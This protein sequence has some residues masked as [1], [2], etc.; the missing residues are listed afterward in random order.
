M[1]EETKQKLLEELKKEYNVVLKPLKDPRFSVTDILDKYN[2]AICQKAGVDN[3]WHY[4]Q[5]IG[6]AIR[7]IM[8]L[9]YGV[10]TTK[11][12]PVKKQEQF[13]KDLEKFIKEFILGEV[14]NGKL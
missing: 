8:C 5:P 6:T 1:D 10:W 14:F 9:S 12:L 2:D 11:E 7:K 3:D 13:R 4:T